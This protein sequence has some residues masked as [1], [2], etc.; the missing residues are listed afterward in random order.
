MVKQPP[1]SLEKEILKLNRQ[2]IREMSGLIASH[3]NLRKYLHAMRFF[4]DEPICRLG[5]EE[6]ETANRATFDCEALRR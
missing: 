5:L 3:C 4:K 2:Q 1:E 6:D